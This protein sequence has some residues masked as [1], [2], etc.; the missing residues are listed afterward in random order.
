MLTAC[1]LALLTVNCKGDSGNCGPVTTERCHTP[2]EWRESG[3]TNFP[4]ATV[5]EDAGCPELE[6]V[7][8]ACPALT[9]VGA[10]TVRGAQYCYQ[11]VFYCY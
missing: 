5:D 4:D 8:A 9:P 10:P 3:C 2:S 7:K 11:E 1:I 6:R